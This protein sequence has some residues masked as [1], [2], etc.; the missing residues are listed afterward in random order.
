MHEE[1]NLSGRLQAKESILATYRDDPSLT[2]SAYLSCERITALLQERLPAREPLDDRLHRRLYG[3]TQCGGD[4]G[5][6]GVLCL[7]GSGGL[8]EL[9]ELLSDEGGM[10]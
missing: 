9:L 4:V 1:V 3:R 8:G 2:R 6:C 5:L 7:D 10:P